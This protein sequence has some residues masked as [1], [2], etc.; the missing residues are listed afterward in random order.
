MQ[1]RD[2]KTVK[3]KIHESRWY[4]DCLITSLENMLGVPREN[5]PVEFYG[6]KS[7]FKGFAKYSTVKH[8]LRKFQRTEYSIYTPDKAK[9]VRLKPC[10]RIILGLK[11]SEYINHSVTY[12]TDSR[13]LIDGGFVTQIPIEFLRVGYIIV[14]D[15]LSQNQ[16][17]LE[18]SD[19]PDGVV[20]SLENYEKMV[21]STNNDKYGTMLVTLA[22]D[23]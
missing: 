8:C 15:C 9:V 22:I 16:D 7:A 14:N 18:K 10:G 5:L 23:K 17:S 19:V 20:E 2:H 11:P 12:D 21:D 4:G 3:N 1:K 13:T 6:D